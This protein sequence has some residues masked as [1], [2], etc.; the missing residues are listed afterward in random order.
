MIQ[1]DIDVIK[2]L[3]SARAPVRH[4]YHTSFPTYTV[5][6]TCFRIWVHK[7]KPW[8]FEVRSMAGVCLTPF[9]R[10]MPWTVLLVRHSLPFTLVAVSIIFPLACSWV[11]VGLITGHRPCAIPVACRDRGCPAG[12]VRRQEV[13][14]TSRNFLQS[15]HRFSPAPV[16]STVRCSM[17]LLPPGVIWPQHRLGHPFAEL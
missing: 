13:S 17:H 2:I 16:Q 3:I 11:S 7:P 1:T 6:N 14:W 5:V 12:G 8:L 9:M 4:N 15:W 10:L